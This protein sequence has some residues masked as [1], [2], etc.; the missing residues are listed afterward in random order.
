MT[1]LT[2][3]PLPP[4]VYWRRR[5]VVLSLALVVA[6]GV[7]RLV[8]GGSDGSEADRASTVAADAST[9]APTPTQPGTGTGTETGTETGTVLPSTGPAP[10]QA[11]GGTT[12]EADPKQGKRGKKAAPPEPVLTEPEGRCDSAD[13]AVTPEVPEAVAGRH[14][15]VVLNLRTVLSPA[16]TWRVSPSNLTLNITSGSDD[17]WSTRECPRA[18]PAEDVV[19]RNNATTAVSVTW[20]RAA[21]MDDECSRI[22]EWAMP[23]YYHATA[24]A[25]GG[26][27][28]DVQFRLEPP[29]GPSASGG[30]GGADKPKRR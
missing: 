20:R 26:E 8:S 9:P 1:S 27:P 30:A 6:L 28:S 17:I 29:S 10:G 11:A 24:A 2:R 4:S 12:G 18:L 3:G 25:L 14:V 13:V 5:L 21:R 15:E 19:I 16:C 22:V 23:G 7:G